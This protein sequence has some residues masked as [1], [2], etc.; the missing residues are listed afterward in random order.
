VVGFAGPLLNGNDFLLKSFNIG[1][2]FIINTKVL[3]TVPWPA[4]KAHQEDKTV[5]LASTIVEIISS[6]RLR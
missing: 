1:D 3:L 6:L 5:A 2:I 4:L